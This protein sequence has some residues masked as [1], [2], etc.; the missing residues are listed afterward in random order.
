MNHEVL[1]LEKVKNLFL[2]D[3]DRKHESY[4]INS[5]TSIGWTDPFVDIDEPNHIERI[6]KIK[7]HNL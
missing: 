7:E 5:F 2:Y 4:F 3:F 6:K 1:N